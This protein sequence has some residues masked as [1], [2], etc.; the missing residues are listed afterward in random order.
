MQQDRP[1][2]IAVDIGGTFTDLQ[3]LDA[4]HGQIRAWKT[5]TT[6]QDPSEGLLLGVREAATR[7][8]FA[9]ADVGLLLHGTT[10]ATNAVLERRLARGVLLTTAGF[11][12]VLEITRHV[13]RDIYGLAPD[14][15]PCLIPRD[16]RLGVAERLR[17]DGSVETPLA[18][19]DL[20]ARLAA[21]QPEAVAVCLLHA[22]ANPMHERALRDA[23]LAA[24]P[25]LPV[26]ISS[27]ISPEIREYE[28][29]STTVLNA[30]LV[31][32]VRDYLR[33]LAAR[34]GQDGFAP[35]I[36][37]VQSNGGVFSLE[38]AAE[39]P[40][41]LLLS[42][43]SGGAL[44]ASRI[45]QELARPN[46]VAVDMGGTSYD[47]SVV[48]QGRVSL[49]TQGEVDG[50][51][52]RLPMVEMRTIGAGGGS[53]ATVEAGG[54]LTVGPRSAGA[55]PGPVA[56][57]R[58]GT[59]PTVTDANLALGRLDADFFLG[60]TMTL[61]MPAAHAA[62][63]RL[64]ATLGLGEEATAE[65]IMALTN[66]SLA[67]AVRLS[68]FEKGL[69]PRD[70]ALL[71]F[72]GAGGL[73]ATEVAEEMGMTEVIF[74]RDP[75]TLSAYGILFSDLV[76]DLARSRLFTL[77]AD[78]LPGLG[79]LIE[80]LRAE[81]DAR[82]ARDGVAAADRALHV[83]ADMRYHGQ[84]FELLVPWG[85]VTQPDAESLA[86]LA[87][88]FH[89]THRQR[90]SYASEAEAVEIVTLRVTATGRLPRPRP[91]VPQPVDR[92]SVK[93][94][95]RIFAHGGWHQAVVWDREALRP[96]DILEGPAIIEEA[97][98][99]H[100]LARGW[101]ARPGA[102]GAIIATKDAAA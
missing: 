98:A 33:R 45:A 27:D 70:F 58:G 82:L 14:P 88:R 2:R 56:Y 15:F 28:R 16:R 101:T 38:T 99:T 7:F 95:R 72:G 57:G 8:G 77:G 63:A 100:Y 23:I 43:P 31:P 49:V 87:A 26:S 92:P 91:A 73:H 1:V 34:L 51:P 64:G 44:A 3:I 79:A 13:R 39:Q 54:R 41:R 86:G 66:A 47:V 21:L 36:F 53:I 93:G 76:Q 68:L 60:G 83:A 22:Y 65:G 78:A 52:V 74:P 29:S 67:A 84:A 20:P 6:P 75:G 11:E 80:E 12:D 37:L 97:F 10:I 62:L 90:F 69:H 50:L 48:Q 5:P 9:L 55:R 25:G 96:D 46:L 42:G 18:L 17:A 24:H 81:A 4:R 19:G 40:A 102:A 89:A 35:R 61:D 30:L 32:V 71:S 59:E 94:T 85:D